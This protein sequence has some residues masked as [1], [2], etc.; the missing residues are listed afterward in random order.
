MA[1]WAVQRFE[2]VRARRG[3]L[4]AAGLAL[5]PAVALADTPATVEGVV[6]T[7]AGAGQQ[8]LLG[9]LPSDQKDI[10]QS[11]TVLDR[12]LLQAQGVASLADAL[13]NVPGITLGG[14]EGS[15]IGN[16]I[17]LNG[18][19]ARTDIFLDGLR[20]RGQYYRDTFALE[21]V[22]VL[23]GPS[24]MLFG[25]GSTGGAINQ[26]SK[27]ARL[28]PSAEAGLSVTSNGLVRGVG[29]VDAPID[30]KSAFRLSAMGQSGAVSTRLKTTVQDYGLAPAYRWGIDGPTEFE[31]NALIQHN[32]D[33]PDYGQPPLNGAPAK[34]GWNTFYGYSDD[35]T[36]QD[37]HA[38]SAGIQQALPGGV[39]LRD[40]LQFNGVDTDARETAPQGIGIVTAKGYA[41]LSPPGIS[42]LPLSALSVQLQSHDRVIHDASLF[43]QLELSGQTRAWGLQNDWLAGVEFGHDDYENQGYYRTGS[44]SGTALKTGNVGCTTLLSPAWTPSPTLAQTAGNLAKGHADTAAVYGSDSLAVTSWLKLVGGLRY[45]RYSATVTNS[46]NASNTAGSTTLASASQTIGYTSARAGVLIEPNPALTGYLSYSTSFNP[47]LEQ[48]TSTTGLSQPLPPED[49]EAFE[50]GIKA[51]PLGERLTL[52]GAV[53]RI[54]QRNSRAQ[55]AD[56]TYSATGTIRAEGLRLGASGR[57][58]RHWQVFAGYT[59]LDAKIIDAIAAGAQGM[60]PANTA[61]DSATLWTTY[62]IKGDWQVGGGATYL[63]RR[64]LNNT[65][66]VQVPGY[67]R[68]DAM[69]AWRQPHYD[70]RLN[71]FNLADA[72]YYDA[73]VQSDGGRA[74]PGSGRTA[75]ISLVWRP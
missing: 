26:A 22:E 46:V 48:L 58:T 65:N 20:D 25:R 24:S 30:G 42:T 70:V 36:I 31:L 18:F 73:L 37:I 34:V 38:V 62:D 61:R 11:V 5:S 8:V 44:C 2:G 16:N 4:A 17:N 29:D 50:A 19:S 74:A 12:A 23:M 3:A 1:G 64:F 6:V 32:R 71:L 40:R 72:H 66:L 41:A 33:R 47:S 59:R 75:M 28:M 53:F 10:P 39:T 21:Q 52:T 13:R 15:Q 67:T 35:R 27:Q 68:L 55:N 54:T 60:V 9:K 57:V 49:N 7:A 14:A 43:D 69:I 56:N 45:D 63:G 51:A